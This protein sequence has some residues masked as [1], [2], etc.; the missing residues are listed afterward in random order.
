MSG[1]QTKVAAPANE[2]GRPEMPRELNPSL[3]GITGF[4]YIYPFLFAI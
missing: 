3:Q 4:L 1:T 2:F